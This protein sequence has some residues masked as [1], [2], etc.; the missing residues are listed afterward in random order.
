MKIAVLFGGISPERE[1]SINGG[2]AVVNALKSLGYEVFPIDP[3]FG[4]NCYTRGIEIIENK[5]I[6]KIPYKEFPLNNY[7]KA[8]NHEVFDNIDLAFLVLHGE[9]CED[10]KIQ[11]LFELRGIP[12]TGSNILSSSLCI[13]KRM[14]KIIFN[15]AG[16]LTPPWL[17]L[18][19]KDIDNYD[20]F[21]DIRNELGPKIVIKPNNQG[22]TFGISIIKDGNLDDINE[23]LKLATKYSEIALAE[24]Y[25][26]GKEITVGIVGDD[27]LPVIEIIPQSG[28]YDYEHKYT[29]GKTEYLCPAEI[30]EDVASFVQDMAHLAFTALNCSGFARADFRLDNDGQ[31]FILEMN[32]IPGFT[33]TSLVPKAAKQIGWD[34]TDLCQKIIDLTINKNK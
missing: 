11:A 21:E 33:E 7:L 19:K 6:D 23:G 18:T 16:I 24:T 9:N 10:G 1:V 17:T 12:Y 28:F 5:F 27:I 25:I 13:D 29:K 22:S 26:Q 30:S 2:K 31:P 15:S 4:V 32:T 8:I 3:A 34:F 20:L 14:S